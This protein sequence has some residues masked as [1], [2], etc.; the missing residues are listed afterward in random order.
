MTTCPECGG[1]SRVYG[2]DRDADT[3]IRYRICKACG[4]KFRT[5]QK[6][7]ELISHKVQPAEP[8]C[9]HKN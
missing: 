2:I 6:P 7:E 8:V 1:R 4:H 5:Y 3:I 9:G